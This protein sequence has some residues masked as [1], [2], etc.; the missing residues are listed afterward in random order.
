MNR[1]KTI[2]K[3]LSSLTLLSPLAGIGFN[4]QY[5][6][7]QNV[8]TENSK[9]LNN[10]FSSNAQEKMG[11]IYVNL[12]DTGKIIQ[13]YASGT[14]SLII[15]NYI[16]QIAD[17]AFKSCTNLTGDLVIPS[18][19]TSIGQQAFW[20]TNITSLDLSN[21]TSL[22]TIG[23]YAFRNCSNITGDLVIPSSLTSIGDDAF[24][25]TKLISFNVDQ[26]NTA[27]SSATNLGPNAK[28]LISGTEG[29]WKD[30][31]VTVA[32][33]ALGDIVIPNT[34]TSIAQ[35]AFEYTNI[36]SL[37]LSQA[38]SLITI[39]GDGSGGE[40]G[41]FADC[42]GLTG[43]LVIPSSLTTIGQYAFYDTKITSLDLSQATSLTDIS[44]RAF[45]KTSITS[46]DLLQATSLTTIGQQ[47]FDQCSS[48]TG[49][50]VIPS[51][52]TS[53]ENYAFA[54]TKITS[55]DL[56]Q[57][58]NLI[59]LAESTFKNCTNLSGNIVIPSSVTSISYSTFAYTNISSLDLSQAT[60]L[61]IIANYAFEH[62]SN[63][64]GNIVIPS[65]VTSIGNQAFANV[66]L[67]NLY[68]LSETQPSFGVD[69]QPTVTGKIYVPTEQAKQKYATAQ[70][71]SFGEDQIEIG[72][73]PEP[74]PK[75]SKNWLPLILG[76]LI[77]I[78]IPVILA[79][80]FIIWY[81]T[82]KKKTTVKI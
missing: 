28:V 56:S 12:D 72:L 6:N 62:C 15:A 68:F 69:W 2:N 14:G 52:V 32:G 50:L 47:V 73:P 64:S 16:T 31:S 81:L 29:I 10:Y 59:E 40:S 71:F 65:S 3:L 39:K 24:C 41:A 58:T 76:L 11:D 67:D 26:N 44:G 77:G 51:S 30:D 33:L 45:S 18:S 5:Q 19:V 34:I 37:D 66:T 80:A 7:T 35:K 43:N 75:K 25:N 79:I 42:K 36:T 48:L 8:I 4:N 27:Y 60:S 70:N 74:T 38:T 61:T 22:T 1:I 78:G 57:A 54:E 63:L 82:K 9:V 20:T 13:S 23:D 21:A 53:I 55:L 46:L 49:N 17:N